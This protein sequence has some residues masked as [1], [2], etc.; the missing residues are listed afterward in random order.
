MSFD[1]PPALLKLNNWQSISV[2]E[3]Q[4]LIQE[5]DEM[6]RQIEELKSAHRTCQ[7]QRTEEEQRVEELFAQNRRQRETIAAI[8]RCRDITQ[9]NADKRDAQQRIVIASLKAEMQELQI[10]HQNLLEEYRNLHRL[11]DAILL[12]LL[13]LKKS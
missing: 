5:W 1:R 12:E 6:V 11:Y 13:E 7:R 3:C 8:G 4:A 2:E 9:A 10:G